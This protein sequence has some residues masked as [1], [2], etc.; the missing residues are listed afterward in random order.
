[1]LQSVM[2]MRY[3][4]SK[5]TSPGEKASQIP[6]KSSIYPQFMAIKSFTLPVLLNEAPKTD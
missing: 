6:V 3:T 4:K 2:S 5:M 1:M